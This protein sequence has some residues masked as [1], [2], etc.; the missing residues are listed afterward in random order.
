MGTAITAISEGKALGRHSQCQTCRV[1]PCPRATWSKVSCLKTGWFWLMGNYVACAMPR[2]NWS[3]FPIQRIRNNLRPF[4][5]KWY[6]ITASIVTHV[7]NHHLNNDFIA[8][9]DTPLE[10]NATPSDTKFKTIE[11]FIWTAS[12]VMLVTLPGCRTQWTRDR[13]QIFW[14]DHPRCNPIPCAKINRIGSESQRDLVLH[15]TLQCFTVQIYR[16]NFHLHIGFSGGW[17]SQSFIDSSP[18]MAMSCSFH[19]LTVLP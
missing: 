10:T 19:V 7:G 5:K 6:T 3:Y 13:C 2:L 16:W 8:W 15:G 4:A 9:F 18:F 17:I 14:C 11:Y 1:H 12:S